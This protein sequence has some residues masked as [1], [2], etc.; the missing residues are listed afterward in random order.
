MVGYCSLALAKRDHNNNF[1]IS[2]DEFKEMLTKSCI[3]ENKK[4]KSEVQSREIFR[5]IYVQK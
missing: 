2:I 5:K 1:P 3:L 4:E